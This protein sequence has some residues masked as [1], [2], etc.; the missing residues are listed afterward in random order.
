MSEYKEPEWVKAISK[1]IQ[2]VD[3]K[4]IHEGDVNS[5]QPFDIVWFTPNHGEEAMRLLAWL[6]GGEDERKERCKAHHFRM[7]EKAPALDITGKRMPGE[8]MCVT[9]DRL[10]SNA[11]QAGNTRDG[12]VCVADFCIQLVQ[13][14]DGFIGGWLKPEIWHYP[15]FVKEAHDQAISEAQNLKAVQDAQEKNSQQTQQQLERINRRYFVTAARMVLPGNA[16]SPKALPTED[17]QDI[18]AFGVLLGIPMVEHELWMEE[19]GSKLNIDV[20][21]EDEPYDPVKFL[22]HASIV[23]SSIAGMRR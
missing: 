7:W 8:M 10:G 1:P 3:T 4:T 19:L 11:I 14:K 12:R 20:P 9:V 15:E 5:R 16:V 22:E 2:S 13:V 17:L 23:A 18:V 6:P 21:N